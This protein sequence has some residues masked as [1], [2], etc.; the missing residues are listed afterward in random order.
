MNASVWFV[1]AKASERYHNVQR[2]RRKV[3]DSM[4]V[5]ERRARW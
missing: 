3:V 1:K 5:Y 2:A 4:A